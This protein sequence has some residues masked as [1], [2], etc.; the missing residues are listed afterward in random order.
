MADNPRTSLTDTPLYR[1]TSSISR[2]FAV[3]MLWLLCSLPIVTM[4]AA[5]AAAMEA[6]LS[7]EGASPQGLVKGYFCSFRKHFFRA[8]G[9]WL[10]TLA[11][12]ALLALDAVFYRQLMKGLPWLLPAAAVILGNLLL[13]LFR[14]GCFAMICREST[15]LKSLLKQAAGMMVLCLPV[16]AVMVALDLAAVTTLT[17]IPYLWV[18]LVILPGLYANIHCRLIQAFLRRFETEES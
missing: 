1:I 17:R 2:W 5:T 13:G 9:L 14:F 4:G 10:L 6:S 12:L 15:G 8:T 7:P 18:C 11:A 16:W 3:S